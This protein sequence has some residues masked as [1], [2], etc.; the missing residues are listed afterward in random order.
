MTDQDLATLLR[1]HVHADE[2]PFSLTPE[3]AISSG[4][5]ARRRSRIRRGLGSA[6]LIG[7][8]ATVA[9]PLVLE[10]GTGDRTARIDPK[11]D[12]ETAAAL[13]DYDAS[14]M[15][16]LLDTHARGALGI[17]GTP[18]FA[19]YD[20]QGEKLP[21][22][23]WDKASSMGV[24]YGPAEH[25]FGV[26]LA[27]ARGEAE[28]N[29]QRYCAEGLDG[30]YYL[31]C[32]VSTSPAG[33]VVISKVT[34]VRPMPSFGDGTMSVVTRETLETG[35]VPEGDPSGTPFDRDDLYF[36]RTVKVVHSETFLTYAEEQVKARSLAAAD[37][38]WR[39][40]V[41]NLI[42]LATDPALVIP[43]PPLGPGGCGWTW[44]A[45][46]TCTKG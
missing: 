33:D 32:E 1:A 5:R 8:A 45:K 28:G 42:E 34:A 12:P 21:A 9:V 44:K 16:A 40:P 46:V 22:R 38:L 24:T 15:P 41:R 35:K 20:D 18:A 2:P 17:S 11:I 36:S 6:A 29:A 19:A 4:R 27:H 3:A 31:R 23:Y 37:D 13:A 26:T 10:N 14:A 30:G 7:V 25:Q 39:V 43:K